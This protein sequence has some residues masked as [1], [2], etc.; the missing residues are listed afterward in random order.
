MLCIISDFTL[1]TVSSLVCCPTHNLWWFC[2]IY[3]YCPIWESNCD[4]LTNL[5]PHADF[6]GRPLNSRL[7][8]ACF[9]YIVQRKRVVNVAIVT[10]YE[11]RKAQL[12]HGLISD[13]TGTVRNERSFQI[14]VIIIVKV[15]SCDHI[16][17]VVDNGDLI[18]LWDIMV[19]WNGCW[20]LLCFFI[21]WFGV[22][23]INVISPVSGYNEP[24]RQLSWLSP[25]GYYGLSHS[26]NH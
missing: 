3:L 14:L 5:Y 19:Y 22:V 24:M 10:I 16:S 6:K 17:L 4:L 15:R 26:C 1:E 25:I 20:Q 21:L 12:K 18:N 8:K 11:H 13:L 7:S 2:F 9:A 23:N